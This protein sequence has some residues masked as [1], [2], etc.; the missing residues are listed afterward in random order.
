MG[1]ASK[2]APAPTKSATVSKS[3]LA[4]R[5]AANVIKPSESYVAWVAR[6]LGIKDEKHLETLPEFL[7]VSSKRA[8]EIIDTLSEIIAT[9]LAKGESVYIDGLGT[10]TAVD[11]KARKGRNPKTGEEVVIAATRRPKLRASKR[12]KEAV[13]A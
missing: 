4:E 5:L 12:L 10:L 6:R 2:S 1:K 11:V 13:A 8:K 7:A 9:A 3:E